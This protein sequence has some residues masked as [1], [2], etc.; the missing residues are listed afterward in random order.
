MK[1][2]E[3]NDLFYIYCKEVKAGLSECGLKGCGWLLVQHL[4]KVLVMCRLLD[5]IEVLPCAITVKLQQE[6]EDQS[7][8]KSNV[9]APRVKKCKAKN[10]T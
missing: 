9:Y 8:S 1:E 10:L 4:V 2:K 3:I 5:P 7:K 6:E